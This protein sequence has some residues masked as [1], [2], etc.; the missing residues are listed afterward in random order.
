[1]GT[2]TDIIFIAILILAFIYGHNKGLVKSVWKIAALI[3][4]IFL[5]MTLK[6]PATEFVSRT[7]LA[8][9]LEHSLS[10]VITVPPGGGVN[11][12]QTLN[13]PE[14]MQHNIQVATGTAAE[15]AEAI[16]NAATKSLA[17]TI[18]VIG[19]CVALFILIR[20]VLMAVFMIINGLTKV[21]LVKGA[22]KFLGG[23]FGM[24]NIVFIVMLA[25]AI[26]TMVAPA[27]NFMYEAI[28]KSY[29]I[30]FLY[31]NN[32]LLRIFMR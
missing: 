9:N 18:L 17:G 4:T 8:E 2:I 3:I 5:V 6:D 22:N 15:T 32:L 13:L 23:L 31:N 26:F 11:I 12:A 20:L 29:I 28:D 14:F 21:P 16:K 10:E 19:V 30:K 25:L 27:D 24:I 7:P 1:M